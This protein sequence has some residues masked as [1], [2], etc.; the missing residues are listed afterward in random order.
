MGLN[1]GRGYGGTALLIAGTQKPFPGSWHWEYST[2]AAQWENQKCASYGRIGDAY[3]RN[4]SASGPLGACATW[5][6]PGPRGGRQ[7]NY[8]G[9]RIY[10]HPNT[11][12][13]AV[14][15]AIG[16]HYV[17]LS[18]A[19]GPL[20]YPTSDELSC[21]FRANCKFNRFETGNI[22][23]SPTTG[24][25]AVYGAIFAEWGR[26]GYENGRFGLPTTDEFAVGADR[27]VN[28]EG[29]WIRWISANN[30]VITS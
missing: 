6:Y 2:G 10:W 19:N 21:P 9:G 16:N 22:Y 20:L 29:G 3:R 25:H 15:G 17:G 23:W 26:Q 13:W 7:Q 12:A 30:T 18:E 24:A 28:F 8:A 27:Q 4:N 5:E 14:F 11:D 1:V